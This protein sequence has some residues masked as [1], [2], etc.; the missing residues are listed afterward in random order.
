M[1]RDL[2]DLADGDLAALALAGRQEAYRLL[3][4]RHRAQIFRIAR[5]QCG[6]EDAALEVTQQAFIAAFAALARY[7]RTR[8]FAHW[9]ARIAINKSHD[10]SRRRKV[11][12]WLGLPLPAHAADLW[13][14]DAPLADDDLADRQDLSRAMAAI[15]DLPERLKDV[16][17]LRAIEGLSQ[18]EVAILLGISAK[19]VEARLYR[20]REKLREALRD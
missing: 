8:P 16:L 12:Q 9:L 2:A 14:D 13:A 18:A 7:D 3:L 10:W 15:A 1:T 4:E 6:D 19:A 17:V 20:A 5:H 11:R